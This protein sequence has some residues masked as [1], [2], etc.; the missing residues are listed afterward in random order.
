VFN[1]HV[2]AAA[3]VAWVIGAPAVAPSHAAHSAPTPVTTTFTAAPQLAIAVADGR[4]S[5][6]VGDQLTYTITVHNLGTTTANGLQISESLPSGLKL[7]SADH[8]GT[9]NGAR[10]TWTL[11]LKPGGQSTVTTVGRVGQTP[12]SLLRLAA[13][14]CATAEHGS[15][16]LVCATHSDLL[17]AG[18]AVAGVHQ[19]ASH[20]IWYG[21]GA[22][23]LAG[24]TVAAF[25]FMRRR[26]RR[27][28][29]L[30]ECL[31]GPDEYGRDPERWDAPSSAQSDR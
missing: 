12:S 10:V 15:K 18:A 4:T 9:A 17:P 14:A 24:I 22:V 25:L 5:A 31:D 19:P 28:A 21:I 2:I 1:A 27:R 29:Q 8:G 6:A 26:S 20:R 11:D 7:V 23:A 30:A 16:P 13:V 3:T